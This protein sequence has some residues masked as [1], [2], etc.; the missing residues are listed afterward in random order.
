MDDPALQSPLLGGES[1]GGAVE[2][3]R[4]P[5][6]VGSK[7]SV[8]IAN[9]LVSKASTQTARHSFLVGPTKAERGDEEAG[10]K[11]DK[12]CTRFCG[13]IDAFPIPFVLGGAAIGL[14]IGIGLSTWNPDDPSAKDVVI[15]WV[16]LI[17]DLFIRAL[18]CIVLP[19]V[20]VSIAISIMD[21][22]SLGEAGTVV[23]MT[24]GLYLLTTVCASLIGVASSVI[25]SN[26]YTLTN[27]V[28]DE[29]D[30]VVRMGCSYDADGMIGSYLTKSE[31]GSV[32]CSAAS[33]GED[34]MFMMDDVNGYFAKSG[35]AEGPAQL[36][37]SESIYQVRFAVYLQALCSFHFPK[38][39]LSAL[40]PLLHYI[41]GLFMQLIDDNFVG[42]FYRS[43][44]LGVVS[45]RGPCLYPPP[46]KKYSPGGTRL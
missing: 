10:E 45:T 29:V 36:T 33:D 26:F 5:T 17:G 13:L 20:F 32:S 7:S 41:Q 43:N 12:C 4:P 42:M 15:T 24:I 18:K 21:M 14:A 2:A 9:S 16:G 1:D 31:G 25:F 23:L 35:L 38:H 46:K 27:G 28:P 39:V 22:L 30:P 40:I 37:L 19:L 44:F 8:R 34:T 6:L 3:Q 11:A